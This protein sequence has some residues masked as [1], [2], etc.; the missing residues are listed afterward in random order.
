LYDLQPSQRIR[1]ELLALGIDPDDGTSPVETLEL[2]KV[3]GMRYEA[4]RGTDLF[5]GHIDARYGSNTELSVLDVGSG[6]GGPSRLL[7]LK[8]PKTNLVALEFVPEISSL[9][10]NLTQ[11]SEVSGCIQHVTGDITKLD[12]DTLIVNIDPSI[13]VLPFQAAQAVLTLL[14]VFDIEKALANVFPLLEDNGIM[15]IEDFWVLDSEKV[16]E[17]AKEHL[18]KRVGCP[19]LPMTQSEWNATLTGVGFCTVEFEDVTANWRPWIYER[20]SEYEQMMDRH[21]RVQGQ[22]GATHMLEFYQTMDTLFS[23]ELKGCRIVA[24][25]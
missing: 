13:Q 19:R 9:A 8:R 22:Q 1:N 23:T 5:R 3:D 16:S 10:K 18:E 6:F 20:A 2:Q 14:H 4:D 12:G 7:A 17:Q 21:I 11:R 15:Y 25:K 24:R